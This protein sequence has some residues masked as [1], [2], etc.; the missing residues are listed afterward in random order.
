MATAR[1]LSA[2]VLRALSAVAIRPVARYV[3]AFVIFALALALRFAI[4]PV[5]AG[6]GFLTFYPAMAFA[7]LLCGIGPAVVVIVLGGFAGYY[8]FMEPYWA[9]KFHYGAMVSLSVYALS[10]TILCLIVRQNQ[11]A[12]RER[13]LLAAIVQS[14]D[15]AI[16]SKTLAGIIT[17]W[18]PEAERLFGYPARKAI[19]QPM[20]MLFP[21][22]RVGEEGELLG[23]ISRGESVSRY[24]TVRVRKDGSTVDVSVTLSPI[25]DLRGR[26][27]GASKIAHDI[28]ARKALEDG[29]KRSNDQLATVVAD[30][31]RSNQELDEFSYIASHDLKEPLRGIHNYVSFLLEDYA[32]RL[33][34]D[35][36]SYLD[37]IQRLAERM[38]ALIDRLLAYSRLGSS[39]L[40]M[41]AVDLDAV[42][43]DVAEDLK[44]ALAEQA[45]E[46]RRTGH[47]PIV[48][49]N[50][51]RLGEVFQNLIGNAVKYNDKSEKWVEVGC[52]DHGATPVF[53]VR[54][55][56][57]GIPPQHRDTIFRIFKRLHEQSKFGGGTGAGLTIVKKIIERHGGRIWLDSNQGEGT[58]FHFTLAE[59]P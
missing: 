56:G 44:F 8:V 30:L 24:E 9:F 18:N 15:D 14:S 25:R 19:G 35:G 36:R 32:E 27:V 2:D 59:G 29:L 46:L 28:T 38:T 57:I 52:D 13:S 23:R 33:D 26:I 3:V 12:E 54:D 16:M 37:R 49:G 58:T 53:F 47:L 34:D 45:V 48:T 22:D 1:A 55:N 31:N 10:G 6:L 21:P 7:A 17:S 5:H 40:A 51:L 50:A 11:K 20:T 4:L 39:P 42:L 41:D 43:D